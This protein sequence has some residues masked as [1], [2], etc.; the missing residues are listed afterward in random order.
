[1]EMFFLTVLF[2]VVLKNKIHVPVVLNLP[3]FGLWGLL[4]ALWTILHFSK[5]FHS[6]GLT[7]PWIKN[8]A[9]FWGVGDVCVCCV[10]RWCICPLG[11]SDSSWLSA[12]SVWWQMAWSSR[13]LM[14]A[15]RVCGQLSHPNRQMVVNF[16]CLSPGRAQWS[17]QSSQ[18]TPVKVQLKDLWKTKCCRSRWCISSF[19]KLLV[20]R[21]GII[22]FGQMPLSR[23]TYS[24]FNVYL[25]P[26][27]QTH[28]AQTVTFELR[29][30]DQLTTW[31]CVTE[32]PHRTQNSHRSQH[33]TYLTV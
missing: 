1:M 21:T 32:T 18:S 4:L 16:L 25:C 33:E 30:S 17:S 12:G 6:L 2:K 14:G 15:V 13:G 23:E 24:A 29:P 8:K 11:V 22:C 19:V 27:K 26:R 28:N 3:V 31:K 20:S 10:C 9:V 7:P 5:F